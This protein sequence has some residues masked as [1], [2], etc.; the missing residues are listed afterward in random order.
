MAIKCKGRNCEI[1]NFSADDYGELV[2]MLDRL[3]TVRREGYSSACY[4][5]YFYI[6]CYYLVHTRCIGLH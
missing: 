3:S 4:C 5:F 6:I 2:P 1:L